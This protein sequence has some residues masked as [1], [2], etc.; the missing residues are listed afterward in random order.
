M[1]IINRPSA[2][3]LAAALAISILP[4]SPVSATLYRYTDTSEARV[5]VGDLDLAD[6]EGRRAFVK[7]MRKAAVKACAPRAYPATYNREVL[8]DC[9]R[10]FSRATEDRLAVAAGTKTASND[11]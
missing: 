6:E 11:D 3:S 5:P 8:R 7:R 2:T 1:H 4:A 10:R 9:K